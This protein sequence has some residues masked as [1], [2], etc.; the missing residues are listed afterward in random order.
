VN[1]DVDDFVWFLAKDALGYAVFKY[2]VEAL[3]EVHLRDLI[4]GDVDG[5]LR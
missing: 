2:G 4:L 5:A 1:F 3:Q